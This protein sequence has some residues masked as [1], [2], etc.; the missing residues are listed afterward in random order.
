MTVLHPF[1]TPRELIAPSCSLPWKSFHQYSAQWL[2]WNTHLFPGETWNGRDNIEEWEWIMMGIVNLGLILEC[3][4]GSGVIHQCGGLGTREGSRFG[5]AS[6]RVVINPLPA[7]KM[8]KLR[9]ILMGMIPSYPGEFRPPLWP[10]KPMRELDH[11]IILL[12]SSWCL[13]SCTS[14][15]TPNQMGRKYSSSLNHQSPTTQFHRPPIGTLLWVDTPS[16]LFHHLDQ[17]LGS[18][19]HMSHHLALVQLSCL[20]WDWGDWEWANLHHLWIP[21]AVKH[22]GF[23]TW[24]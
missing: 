16:S 5:G 8:K 12:L 7:L 11:I 18:C 14:G 19:W 1:S 21:L 22:I 24:S 6:V 23:T 4:W 13:R 17:A 3:G 15:I 10:L 9:W 20:T 2:Y